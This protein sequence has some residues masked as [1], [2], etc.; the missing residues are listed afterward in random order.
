MLYAKPENMASSGEMLKTTHL[1]EASTWLQNRMDKKV[2]I[3]L[4]VA[5]SDRIEAADILRELQAV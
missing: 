2:T 4:E 5:T 1:A 3:S